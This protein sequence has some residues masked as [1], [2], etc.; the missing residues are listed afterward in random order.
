MNISACS[1]LAT[2]PGE[3]WRRGR[4]RLRMEES[5]KKK[6]WKTPKHSGKGYQTYKGSDKLAKQIVTLTQW[7]HH[8]SG[9][10]GFDRTT[11]RPGKLGE[12]CDR[13]PFACLVSV[14]A[15]MMC[16]SAM[17]HSRHASESRPCNVHW[18]YLV[19]G[20]PLTHRG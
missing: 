14:F 20:F 2:T 10:S 3:G 9:W 7:R 4:K 5:W 19:S 12:S 16:C 8:R 1:S 11:F 13:S 15:L 6:K 18:C 17:W